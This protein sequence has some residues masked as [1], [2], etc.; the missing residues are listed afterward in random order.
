MTENMA[1]NAAN[2]SEQIGEERASHYQY[3]IKESQHLIAVPPHAAFEIHWASLDGTAVMD[4]KV[5]ATG[6]CQIFVVYD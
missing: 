6:P 4:S 3:M 2:M 1:K 5:R